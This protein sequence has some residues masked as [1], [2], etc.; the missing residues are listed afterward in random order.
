MVWDDYYW[1]LLQSRAGFTRSP[2]GPHEALS[3]NRKPITLHIVPPSSYNTVSPIAV[4]NSLAEAT[5]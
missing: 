4:H 2:L 3:L 1:H 5:T